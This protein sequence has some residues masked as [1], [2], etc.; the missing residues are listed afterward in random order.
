[1]QWRR[2]FGMWL[3][4]SL[5]ATCIPSRNF[6]GGA[7]T[8]Q[9]RACR[10]VHL[11]RRL[12]IRSLLAV[13]LLNFVFFPHGRRPYWRESLA[14]FPHKRSTGAL[15]GQACLG[16]PRCLVCGLAL[17][18]NG[19]LLSFG[20]PTYVQQTGFAT[21]GPAAAAPYVGTA[22]LPKLSPEYRDERIL[23]VPHAMRM[24]A[25]HMQPSPF[26]AMGILKAQII[27]SQPSPREV[28]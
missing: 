28:A 22:A 1:M 16:W 10:R 9:L 15:G 23:S 8:W 13:F 3:L 20:P 21:R 2:S 6:M 4:A 25:Q 11:L 12:H 7:R 17:L 26:G 18:Q 19:E 27:P 14:F 24:G 5:F